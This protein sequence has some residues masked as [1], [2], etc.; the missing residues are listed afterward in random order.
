[1]AQQEAAAA[2]RSC[3]AQTAHHKSAPGTHTLKACG[4]YTQQLTPLNL[5]YSLCSAYPSLQTVRV[6]KSG[7]TGAR[8][9]RVHLALLLWLRFY[10]LI[11][12]VFPFGKPDFHHWHL[13][14]TAH[15]FLLRRKKAT[16]AFWVLKNTLV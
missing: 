3:S 2:L 4:S 6:V 1:M 11:A 5:C 13:P 15:D 7:A 9:Q 16:I 8:M 12:P 10:E 14:S